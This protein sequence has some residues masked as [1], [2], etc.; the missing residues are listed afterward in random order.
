MRVAFCCHSSTVEAG[1]LQQQESSS[2]S[3]QQQRRRRRRRQAASS[4]Q[5][6]QQQQAAA[7]AAATPAARNESEVES[8][9]QPP[10]TH[11][12]SGESERSL[13]PVFRVSATSARA[14]RLQQLVKVKDLFG[15]DLDL[16]GPLGGHR[17]C[18]RDTPSLSCSV[19]RP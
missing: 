2:S 6:Q 5:Q 13:H 3:E 18:S 15:S 16:F 14:A 17:V 4:K 12:E 8:I 7:A 9:I 19:M 10:H 11:D 1:W